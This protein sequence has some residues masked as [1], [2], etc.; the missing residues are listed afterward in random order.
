MPLSATNVKQKLV[1]NEDTE[2]TIEMHRNGVQQNGALYFFQL[3]QNLQNYI[4]AETKSFLQTGMSLFFYRVSKC[5]TSICRQ[6]RTFI[7]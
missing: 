2:E 6:R 1:S 5:Q 4:T 3:F 7:I